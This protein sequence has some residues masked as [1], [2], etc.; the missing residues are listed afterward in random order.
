MLRAIPSRWIVLF[1]GR[2]FQ[3]KS[4]GTSSLIFGGGSCWLSFL[5]FFVLLVPIVFGSL[6]KPVLWVTT[7]SSRLW[8][9]KF[10]QRPLRICVV[11]AMKVSICSLIWAIESPL[12]WACFAYLA[13]TRIPYLTYNFMTLLLYLPRTCGSLTATTM[14]W[15]PC[16]WRRFFQIWFQRAYPSTVFC[17]LRGSLIKC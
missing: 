10:W 5:L 3:S 15:T 7:G 12:F 16:I 4:C 9:Y 6:V 1:I 17:G 8:V 13:C 11:T 14:A 2:C